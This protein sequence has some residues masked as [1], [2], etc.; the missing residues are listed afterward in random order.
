[1][2]DL[3]DRIIDAHH[4]ADLPRP[5]CPGCAA[6]TLD[7]H[8]YGHGEQEVPQDAR[9]GDSERFPSTAPVDSHNLASGAAEEAAPLKRCVVCGQQAGVSLTSAAVC[10]EHADPLAL[11]QRV[12]ELERDLAAA[13][14]A[15]E[16]L[17]AALDRGSVHFCGYCKFACPGDGESVT[18]HVL[19]C[20]ANP[21]VQ[22]RD[23]A[24]A[25]RERAGAVVEAA[26][27]VLDN[28]WKPVQVGRWLVARSSALLWSRAMDHLAAAIAAERGTDA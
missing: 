25:E 4:L 11:E 7:G 14:Q 17:K 1:V 5:A 15:W 18:Q 20:S 6:G 24:L 21:L 27:K 10:Q 13:Q 3:A 19:T 9:S 16:H 8:I 2:T 23:A 26:Q 22:Q 12:G 28:S